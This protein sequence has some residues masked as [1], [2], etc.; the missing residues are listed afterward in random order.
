MSVVEKVSEIQRKIKMVIPAATLDKDA[1]ARLQELA[2]T[3][4]MDGYRP[5]KVPVSALKQRYGVA[6]RQEIIG[7][8][9]QKQF[10]AI[11]EQEK[12]QPVGLPEI[13]VIKNEAGHDVEFHAVFEVYPEVELQG[14]DQIKLEKLTSTV[15]DADVDQMMQTL[16]QQQAEW[17]EVTRAAKNDDRVTIDFEGEMDGK[18]F[19]GG[20]AKD[21]PLVLGSK[22]MI[23]GFEAG[24]VGVKTGDSKVLDLHFP[25]E[26]FAKDLAGKA[27][28]FTVHVKAIAEPI[29]AELDADFAKKFNVES[30]D[31]LRK[32]VR[33]NMER[34]LEFSL[35][36]RFKM[37][38]MNE[39]LKGNQI[40]VPNALVQQ[41]IEHLKEQA[42]RQMGMMGKKG[43]KDM[44]LPN[45]LFAEE[46]KRRVQLGVL[47]NRVIVTNDIKPD[48]ARVKE[49]LTKM[50]SIYE[51][52][53]EALKQ[54]LQD[55]QQVAQVEQ[56]VLEEQVVEKLCE[57][58]QVTEVK[59]G[60]YDVMRAQ[61]GGQQ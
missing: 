35:K 50:A 14:L 49:T 53:E 46:A 18:V 48:Q 13:D 59:K 42:M 36:N 15:T 44:Q 17:K 1:E 47:M 26:Y 56:S 30:I 39:L 27:V 54:Y 31:A 55:Q 12:L 33:G 5:G 20:S 40:Q 24:L 28:K 3:A 29:L 58:I 52:P 57:S 34:E 7:E 2:K 61:Q 41:E 38:L 43:G 37:Q 32:E 25:Q 19:E 22:Q 4:R 51:A 11:T 10:Q 23:E 45:E 16:R 21:V 6:I 9:M 60:F 8:A